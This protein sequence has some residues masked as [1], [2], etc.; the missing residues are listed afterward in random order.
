MC[1]TLQRR[2][3]TSKWKGLIPDKGSLWTSCKKHPDVKRDNMKY[4]A[5]D[6][7]FGRTAAIDKNDRNC[8]VEWRPTLFPTPPNLWLRMAKTTESNM[9]TNFTW[10]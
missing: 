4:G 10:W 9:V 3:R 8:Q 6:T 1:K 5:W 2:G 7:V